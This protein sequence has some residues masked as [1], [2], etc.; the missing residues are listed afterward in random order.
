MGV[1]GGGG[2]WELFDKGLVGDVLVFDVGVCGC[3]GIKG[4]GCGGGRFVEVVD[5]MVGGGDLVLDIVGVG[6]C[7]GI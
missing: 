5:R 2:G 6:V 1:R 3:R 4:D 7:G